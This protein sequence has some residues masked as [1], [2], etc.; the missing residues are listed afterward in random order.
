MRVDCALQSI[1]TDVLNEL[2][3]KPTEAFILPGDDD[4]GAT[5]TTTDEGGA[6]L[7]RKQALVAL[8]TA[9]GINTLIGARACESFCSFAADHL[10]M[11][12]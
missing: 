3:G 11:A 6:A 10:L 8:Q 7:R 1:A 4:H 5:S 12:C 9:R 2:V